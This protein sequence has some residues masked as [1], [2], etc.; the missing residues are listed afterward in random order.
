MNHFDAGGYVLSFG[1]GR[2]HG[3]RHVDI[4]MIGPGGRIVD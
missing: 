4:T 3:S 2:H 1:P